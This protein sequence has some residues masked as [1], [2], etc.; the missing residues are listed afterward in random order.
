LN[1]ENAVLAKAFYDNL[2]SSQSSFYE[3]LP[4]K[5][6]EAKDA[7]LSMSCSNKICVISLKQRNS[8]KERDKGGKNKLCFVSLT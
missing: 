6:I 4:Q 2:F 3:G 8:Q 1:A 7:L 5:S